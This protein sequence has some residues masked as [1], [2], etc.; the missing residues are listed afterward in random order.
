MLEVSHRHVVGKCPHAGCESTFTLSLGRWHGGE[1]DSGGFVLECESCLGLSYVRVPNPDDASSVMSG[2]RK[3]ATW[4]DEVGGSMEAVLA[5]HRVDGASAVTEQML[6]PDKPSDAT[7]RFDLSKRAIHV[8]P[9]CNEN[10]ETL[11]YQALEDALGEIN[12]QVN[13]FLTLLLKGYESDVDRIEVS[14]LVN[15]RCHEN[16]QHRVTFSRPYRET[17]ALAENASEYDLAGPLSADFLQD[18]DGIYTRDECLDILTKLLVRWQARNQVVLIAVPFIGLDYPGREEN[19]LD[20]WNLIL[21]HTNPAR[22]LVMTRSGTF[23]GFLKAAEQQG[24]NIPMLERFNLL[25]PLLQRFKSDDA[26]FKQQSHAK[27]YAAMG[28]E[29]TEVLTG[30][31]NV[32]SGSYVENLVFKT[33]SNTD[34]LQR[35]L[36]PMEVIFDF[37]QLRPKQRILTVDI[38]SGKASPFEIK[39]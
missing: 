31:F 21:R 11:A 17:S 9:R 4:D 14:V 19:R 29:R 13:R 20:L 5:A 39:H 16:S 18:I 24:L 15:C 3:V 26:F 6:L 2:A 12:D 38:T 1:N 10:L 22:T 35:Y 25:A 27:F 8:C 23:K 32:H 36:L 37:R 34:F 28:P 30:S 33:Y 7:P